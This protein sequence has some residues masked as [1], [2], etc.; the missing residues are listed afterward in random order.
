M[1]TS[2]FTSALA[3]SL[4]CGPA[5]A[6]DADALKKVAAEKSTQTPVVTGAGGWLYLP[7]ELSHIAAGKFWG[8]DAAKVSKAPKPENADPLPAILDF[9]SQLDKAGIELILVPVPA[10][11]FVYPEPLSGQEP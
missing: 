9:K 6:Q 2:L 5:I 10:K 7:A 11:T 4:L 8:P 3:F 1:K